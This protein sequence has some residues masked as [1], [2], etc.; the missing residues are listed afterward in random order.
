VSTAVEKRRISTRLCDGMISLTKSD[1]AGK[2]ECMF[3]L[4]GGVRLEVLD[5]P[6]SQDPRRARPR[7]ARAGERVRRQALC[8]LHHWHAQ[9][10][11]TRAA[12]HVNRLIQ[13]E[14]IEGTDGTG[15]PHDETAP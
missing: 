15:D 11:R 8:A 9:T 4:G 3:N 1:R 2:L 14:S 5:P 7:G 6:E 13:L 12:A 10:D